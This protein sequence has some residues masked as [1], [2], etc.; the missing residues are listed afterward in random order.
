MKDEPKRNYSFSDATLIDEANEKQ[1]FIQRDAIDFAS[2]NV[3]ASDITEFDT[4]INAFE[5]LPPDNV[6]EA[7]ITTATQVKDGLKDEV[8][9]M[10]RAVLTR[11]K[12]VFGTSSGKY[13]EM[14]EPSISQMEDKLLLVTS[15]NIALKAGQ[16]LSDLASAGLTQSIIDDLVAKNQ[17]FEEAIVAKKDTVAARDTAASNR[18]RKGN[19]IYALLVKYCEIGKTIY[20]TVDEAK[21]NDYIIYESSPNLPGKVT[22]LAYD[23]TTGTLTYDGLSDAVAYEVAFAP[24]MPEPI[25]I[26]IYSGPDRSVVYD[27]GGPDNYLFRVRAVN[28]S[29]NKGEWSDV[30]VVT[31][32]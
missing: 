9:T 16:Y 26:N 4:L 5:V 18:I 8:L 15:R 32:S 2:Y 20:Y 13:K 12:I 19:E 7:E 21:Y 24:D 6:L 11:A 27:P 17:E 25:F 23:Q 29:G 31:R 22:G 30:L 3:N 1:S 14:N 10:C 28:A